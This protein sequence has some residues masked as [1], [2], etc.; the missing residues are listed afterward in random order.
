MRFT[1]MEG[2]GNDYV[3]VD[4]AAETVTD[5][6]ALARRV[7]DRRFGVG[8]D[9][10]ILIQPSD[11]AAVR[12]EMY[13]AYGSR[14]E[15]CGN[16]LRCVARYAHDHGLAPGPRMTIDTDAGSKDVEVLLSEGSVEGVRVNMGPPILERHLIPMDPESGG[17]GPVIAEPLYVQDHMFVTTCV[18][19]GNPHCVIFVDE[20]AG[21]PV[22]RVGA[23]IETHDAFPNRANVEF[24]RVSSRTEVVQRTWER[25]S[26]ETHACGTGACATV[27]AARLNGLVDPEVI[28]HL[29]GG[30]LTVRWDGDDAPVWMTGPAVEVFRGELEV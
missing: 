30:D 3:Y 8:S 14:G 27:V 18:S 28:V 19:M 17:P 9:G 5:A 6:P 13:N 10:L 2:L 23:A 21:F 16:G 20:P 26:G 7:S 22:A 15:M 1:K 25:G 11:S 4:G 24:V 29:V 12:M